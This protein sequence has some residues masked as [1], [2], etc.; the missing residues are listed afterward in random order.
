MIFRVCLVLIHYLNFGFCAEMGLLCKGKTFNCFVALLCI[1]FCLSAYGLCS[2][3]LRPS[4]PE[5]DVCES[6]VKNCNSG[7]SGTVGGGGGLGSASPSIHNG[8]QN[9]CP[10]A[11]SFRAPSSLKAASLGGSGNQCNGPFCVGL[12]QDSEVTRSIKG[13]LLFPNTVIH[14]G[15]IYCNNLHTDL[16]NMSPEV[17]N[18]Q[19]NCKLVVLTNDT[20][21]PQVEIPCE[22]APHICFEHQRLSFVGSKDKTKAEYAVRNKGLASN[23][24]VTETA[25]VDALVFGN[26]VSLLEDVEVLFPMVQVGS[27][28]SKWI[29]VKNPSHHPVTVQLILNTEEIVDECRGPEDI[30][31]NFS[32]ANLVI[33]EVISAAKYGFSVTESAVTEAYVHP[34]DYATL[35]PII[36]YPSKRCRWNGSALIR[37]NL[38]GIES[39]PLRGIGG[40]RSLALLERSEHVQNV[41]FDLQMHNLLSFSLLYSLLHMKDMIS[42]CSQ[43]LVKE[44]YAKNMGDL[45]LAVKTLRVSGRECGLDGFKI[46]DCKGFSLDP[47]ESIK[48]LISYQTDFS[49]ATVHRDLE[50][51]LPS[52]IFLIPMKASVPYDVLCNCKK[53]LFWTRVKKWLLG[54]ILFASLFFM[55][56]LDYLCKNDSNSVH[57]TLQHS[58]KT[59]LVLPC[60]QR[61]D[62]LSMSGK[63]TNMVCSAGKG[64]AS[65]IRTTCVSYSYDLSETSDKDSENRKQFSLLLDTPKEE[66]SS[67]TAVQTSVVTKPP[68]QSEIK[69]KTGKEKGRRKKKNNK[70]FGAKLTAVSEVSSSRSGNSTPS[71][72]LSPVAPASTKSTRPLS[73]D[74]EQLQHHNKF[75]A[76]TSASKKN[77]SKHRVPVKSLI[78]NAASPKVSVSV[79]PSPSSSDVSIPFK[80]LCAASPPMP[81][82][83]SPSLVSTSSF[84]LSRRA[85]GSKLDK[86]KSVLAPKKIG[87][88]DE[89]TYD[90]WGGH[91]SGLHLLV[92]K[93]VTCMKSSPDEKNFNSFFVGEPQ[94]IK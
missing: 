31:Q 84:S 28:V 12:A 6:S 24:K 26:R 3:N 54:I 58:G 50:L 9:V 15:V 77:T 81:A 32:A 49:A 67:T 46:Q 51:A 55:A 20:T 75:Q 91:L 65:P 34:Y 71:S 17:S 57:I 44:I 79:S 85:P 43:P 53:F 36:F 18:L 19:E 76:S 1:F 92:P 42:V 60:N 52:G 25:D 47:G 88:A 14:V 8:F 87:V 30:I 93:D 7:F 29:T 61:K 68:Q 23:V 80:M 2:T 63:M 78:D 16:H 64:T 21:S 10:D 73:P 11:H 59:P 82:I 48:L 56:S 45:P 4:S 89:Y 70:S 22:D 62:K 13:L 5:Y 72:P 74:V 33:D 38:T 66:K 35:G 90:I 27:Y 39:I 94:S 40:L 86:Q 83:P 41:N 69:I 37:N